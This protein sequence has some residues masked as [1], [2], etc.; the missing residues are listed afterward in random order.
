MVL[1]VFNP[2]R[3]RITIN[4]HWNPQAKSARPYNSLAPEPQNVDGSRIEPDHQI[5][6][7][8]PPQPS[9]A[10]SNSSQRVWRRIETDWY[11]TNAIMPPKGGSTK[12][13]PMRLPPLPKLRVRRPNQSEGNPC[14]ALM[15]SVLS[16]LSHTNSSSMLRIADGDRAR[17]LWTKADKTTQH[18]GPH[19]ATQPQDVKLSRRNYGHVWIHQYVLPPPPA[20]ALPSPSSITLQS[21]KH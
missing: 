15:S 14:L 7:S 8:L 4:K 17:Y 12:L 9:I 20:P 10:H 13:Q 21:I 11:R 5:H 3:S 16:M 6:Y 18:A 1:V 2:V 19:P